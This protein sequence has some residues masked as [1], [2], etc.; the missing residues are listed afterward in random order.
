MS[1]LPKPTLWLYFI[2]FAATAGCTD[3]SLYSAAG[4]GANLP[5]RAA[6]EGVVCSPQVSGRYYPTRVL[7]MVQGGVDVI[8]NNRSTISDAIGAAADRY[9]TATSIRWGLA[10]FNSYALNLMTSTFGDRT[11]LALAQVRYTSFNQPGPLSLPHALSLV[12]SLLSGE[13]LN[14]CPGERARTRYSVVLI[15]SKPDQATQCPVGD[16]CHTAASCAACKAGLA[17]QEV[18]ALQQKYGAG[19]VTVQP[20]FLRLDAA[21]DTDPAVVEVTAEVAAMASA[22]GSQPLSSE[23]SVLQQSLLGL[24]LTGLSAPLK[25]KTV[26]AF[27]RNAMSRAG[28]ILVDSDGDGLSDEDEAALGT[29]PANADTDGDGLKD[30]IEVRASM[31]PLT[32]TVVN[33]CDTTLDADLDGLS[34]CEERLVGTMD[35]MGDTDGDGLPDLVEVYSGTEPLI[36]E[37]TRDGDRDGFPNLDEVRRHTDPRST[38]LEFVGSRSYTYEQEELPVPQPGS[39]PD[40][41]CPGRLRYRV[42][43]SNVGLVSTLETPDHAAGENEIDVYAVFAPNGTG[44]GNLA[45]LHVEPLV[46]IPPSTRR[47][48]EPTISTPEDTFMSRP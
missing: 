46:F 14:Q 10:G 18:R 12:Q 7:F 33:G 13:M 24:N 26:V 40:D 31:D 48:P 8:P 25:L 23:L 47:P 36:Q 41:P 28:R 5:D 39:V 43:V 37:E 19:E 42:R 4:A 35:C 15:T 21:P 27:N 22:G 30:G 2:A 44:L 32:D 3:A 17:A 6:L 38:D 16:S 34:E 29:N 9:A 45:R 1:L 20:I 11:E